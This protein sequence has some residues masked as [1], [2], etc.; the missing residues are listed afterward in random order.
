MDELIYWV[1]LTSIPKL[2]V[3][4]QLRLIEYFG[5][6]DSVF[7]AKDVQE[8]GI[9]KNAAELFTKRDLSE[10]KRIIDRIRQIGGYILTLNDPEYPDYLRDIAVPPPILYCRG[11]HLEWKKLYRLTVVGTRTLSAYGRR[12]TEDIVKGLAR[13]GIVI[14]SGMARGIDSVAAKTAL[15]VGGMSVA[16][17]GS[18]LDV[19]YPPE[20]RKLYEK[21]C[22]K[23]V[24]M[25]EFP[26]GTRPH[27]E[28][29]P[30]RNRIM[31]GLSLGVLIGQAPERSGTLITAAHAIAEGRNVYVIPSDIYDGG[32]AGSN[33]L[34]QQGA[35]LVMCSDDIAEDYPYSELKE[36]VG[37]LPERTVELEGLTEDEAKL[38]KLLM[39]EDLHIDEMIRRTGLTS[40]DANVALMMLEINGVIKKKEHNV[41][42]IV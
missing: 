33:K 3:K 27:K 36:K 18:G 6:P 9:S 32:F 1:W 5:D 29:F 39:D 42:S 21:I 17:L 10:A 2:S 40:A 26:P 30:R 14:V 8:A 19:I 15:G 16:V 24:V 13:L 35:K 37:E 25:T 31:A 23:G 11:Q 28:N 41:F 4:D 12:A 34:I 20:H 22:E 7:S 38:V